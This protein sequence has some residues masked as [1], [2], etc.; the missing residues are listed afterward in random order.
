MFR[1]FV[2]PDM[3]DRPGR[4]SLGLLVGALLATTAFAQAPPTPQPA[5]QAQ[6]PSTPRVFS[7]DAGLVLNFIKSDKTE[8]FEA[9]IAKLKEALGT[10]ANPE[11]KEQA[12]SWKVF[13]S[14]DPGPAGS[15]IYVFITDPAVK[16]ADYT[17]STILAGAFPPAEVNDLTKQ[18]AGAYA[19]GQNIVNL[20]LVSDLGK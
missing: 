16:G 14:P 17:V 20:S 7:S 12:R 15:V 10:S 2:I 1:R 8:E 6:V 5:Q 19:Q 9:V 18:Y 3:R 13:R 11:R 4:A